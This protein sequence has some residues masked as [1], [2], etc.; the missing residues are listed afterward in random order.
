[1]IQSMMKKIV[2]CLTLLLSL[3][4][5]A[6]Y[7]KM[8]VFGDSLS[9][10]GNL[11]NAAPFIAPEFVFL[12]DEPYSKGFTNGPTAVVQ[13]AKLLNVPLTP[14]D[15]LLGL[16]NGYNFAVAGAR[17]SGNDSIDLNI[18]IDAFLLSQTSGKIPQ[19][20]LYV[21]FIGGND[22]RDMRDQTSI[23]T[24]YGILKKAM[25][26]IK[27]SLSQL[28]ALGAKHV[29]VVNSPD[30]GKL[31]ET[32]AGAVKD[33][34]LIQRASLATVVYNQSLAE[35]V[36]TVETS[37]GVDVVLFDVYTL[38]NN[39]VKDRRAYLY[40]N[41]KAACYSSVLQDYSTLCSKNVMDSFVFFD[42]IHPTQRVH[43]RVG[44][45]MF[46]VVPD[47]N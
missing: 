20:A 9:D 16:L 13:L 25:T 1:M 21:L 14:S 15:Y 18:Q 3:S 44:R 28:I 42:E 10:N 24:A 26:N 12:N 6:A 43:E 37:T 23:K 35:T 34:T 8:I 46:A 22:I 38:F 40:S 19:D 27:N 33:K 32:V 45:A 11:A 36:K 5:Q 29:L 31:P 2:I 17:A 7:D 47:A 39:I 41:A 4:V 30:I